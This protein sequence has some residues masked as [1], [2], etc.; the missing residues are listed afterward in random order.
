M[1]SQQRC[2]PPNT[3]PTRSVLSGKEFQVEST[4]ARL[5]KTLRMFHPES[6]C[7]LKPALARTKYPKYRVTRINPAKRSPYKQSATSTLHLSLGPHNHGSGVL[8]AFS[9]LLLFAVCTTYVIPSS[10][11]LYQ[12]CMQILSHIHSSQYRPLSPLIHGD[13]VHVRSISILAFLS[14]QYE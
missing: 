6:Y 3:P 2:P 9:F 14:S 12:F 8:G 1:P 11:S 7:T 13:V 10:H 5:R 4:K